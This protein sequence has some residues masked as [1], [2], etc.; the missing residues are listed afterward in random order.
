MNKIFKGYFLGALAAAC[1]GLIP[2]FAVNLYH[3][4]F[5]VDSVLFYR[6]FVSTIFLGIYL[7]LK[8]ERFLLKNKEILPVCFMGL[9][10]AISS[11]TLF[12]SYNYL[13]IGIAS[14]LL[15]VYPIM[16]AMI[17]FIFFREKLSFFT[18]ISILFAVF[19]IFLLSKTNDG[20]TISLIGVTFVIISAL[21]Y[22]VYMIAINKS[23]VS[24]LSP[25]K[26]TFYV[27]IFALIFISLKILVN[28]N[29]ILPNSISNF[30]NILGLAVFPTV[31]S[32]ISLSMAIRLIGSTYTAVLGA[33]E[34]LTGVMV[35]ILAFNEIITNRI[36][37]GIILVLIAVSIIIFDKKLMSIIE[38]KFFNKLH[39]HY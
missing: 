11:F 33:L 13:N 4:G 8:R 15:F 19:G 30:E 17:N 14:T 35:G 9:L 32:F 31:I 10:F 26:L 21:S 24:N 1:Y 3:D 36:L 27:L 38:K 23:K 37:I 29:L 22:S 39:K 2:L 7:K 6:F 20:G 34:P 25:S 5:N 18:I 16:V 12:I 28:D